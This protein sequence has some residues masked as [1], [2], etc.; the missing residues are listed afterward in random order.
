MLNC[1]STSKNED[2]KSP[3]TLTLLAWVVPITTVTEGGADEAADAKLTQADYQKA[4]GSE[5]HD[6]TYINFLTRLERGGGDQVLRYCRTPSATAAAAAAAVSAASVPTTSSSAESESES[7]SNLKNNVT[8][9]NSSGGRSTQGLLLLSSNPQLLK[10]RA[11]AIQSNPCPRCGAPRTFECQVYIVFCIVLHITYTTFTKYTVRRNI[12]TMLFLDTFQLHSRPF[13]F[14]VSLES[15]A[16]DVTFIL[17]LLLYCTQVMPQLLHFL[18]VDQHTRLATEAP[19]AAPPAVSQTQ[20]EEEG[21][22]VKTPPPVATLPP[23]K[24]F[25]N[26]S[27]K[28]REGVRDVS[29][30]CL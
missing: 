3:P 20:G 23:E 14:L 27:D 17:L 1:T 22:Q 19:A 6:P 7:A 9:N 11:A 28:V 4:L 16:A 12:C 21:G 29:I 18:K 2:E 30:L 24:A 5:A 15:T 13:P 10:D 8:S 26:V 25:F